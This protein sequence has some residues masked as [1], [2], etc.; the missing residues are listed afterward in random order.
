MAI[1]LRFVR[2]LTVGTYRLIRLKML[3]V[4]L[5]KQIDRGEKRYI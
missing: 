4:F 2:E 1:I 3:F 5:K